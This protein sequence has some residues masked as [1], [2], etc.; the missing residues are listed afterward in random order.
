MPIYSEKISCSVVDNVLLVHQTTAK[1]VLLYD[2][3]TDMKSPISAPLPLLLRGPSA[4]SNHENSVGSLDGDDVTSLTPSES[5]IYAEN[6]VFANPDIILDHAH[7]ILW[8][9]HLDLAVRI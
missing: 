7:G 5:N 6:W 9:V 1:V 8:R 4:Y 2:I 3:F